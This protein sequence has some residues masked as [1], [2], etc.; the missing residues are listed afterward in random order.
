M[1]SSESAYRQPRV[2]RHRRTAMADS[3][4]VAASF[5]AT[6]LTAGRE[7]TLTFNDGA[8]LVL[9]AATLDHGSSA[10]AAQ[11]DEAGKRM[12]RNDTLLFVRSNGYEAAVCSFGGVK[13]NGSA[14]VQLS[15]PLTGS[16]VLYQRGADASLVVH[17]SGYVRG[18]VA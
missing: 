3:G 10:P 5:W 14:H 1:M 18:E 11:K 15:Q 17:V 8:V 6:Q 16:A 9:T 4:D 2:L 12:R 7:T 13:W